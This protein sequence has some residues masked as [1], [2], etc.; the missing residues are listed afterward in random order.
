MSDYFDDTTSWKSTLRSEKRRPFSATPKRTKTMK[1]PQF[2]NVVN[3]H[4][5]RSGKRLF[6]KI[7]SMKA[8]KEI[9]KPKEKA[10]PVPA[11][12][13]CHCNQCK[14]MPPFIYYYV[15]QAPPNIE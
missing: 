8:E 4:R 14:P 5:F 10:E 13:E 1:S 2:E 9:K 12:H 15:N 11:A 6:E 7:A 3:R